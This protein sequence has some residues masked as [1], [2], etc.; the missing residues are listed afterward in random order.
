VRQARAGKAPG[1]IGRWRGAG[2]N[3]AMHARFYLPGV[4][5]Q[6]GLLVELPDDESAHLAQVLR[7]RPGDIVS[8]FDGAGREFTARVERPSR[9]GAQATLL[10]QV[11]PRAERL[12]HLT[13]A[14]AVLKGE[15]FDQVVRDATMAGASAIVPIVAV[16]AAVAPAVAARGRR[17]DRW[18]RIAVSSAKQCGRASL[19]DIGE[20]M[21]LARWLD[22]DRADARMLLAEPAAGVTPVPLNT[23]RNLPVPHSVSLLAGPEGGWTDAEVELATGRGVV[24]LTLGA[25]TLRADAAG[26][27]AMAALFALWDVW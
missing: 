4:P 3:P 5:A 1:Q 22:Q 7:A 8:I 27:V 11:T 23:I 9:R 24:P 25:L 26:L 16:Q 19:P 14:Q 13:L 21:A 6:P 18:R 20:P 15:G 12:V 2:Y 17:I 10:A